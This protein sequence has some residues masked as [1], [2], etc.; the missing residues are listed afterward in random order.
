MI[1]FSTTIFGIFFIEI[2]SLQMRKKLKCK[3]NHEICRIL[4]FL[5]W[6]M[7][8]CMEMPLFHFRTGLM[9]IMSLRK[10]FLCK[11]R[12]CNM[13]EEIEYNESLFFQM[14]NKCQFSMKFYI[15]HT[16]QEYCDL[17]ITMV[18]NRY[19]TLTSYIGP[20]SRSYMSKTWSWLTL[21]KSFSRLWFNV[22]SSVQYFLIDCVS[23]FE[24][25]SEL[26]STE[27]YQ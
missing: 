19:Y 16:F 10:K 1:F 15:F 8:Y 3:C 13:M 12:I 17:L 20:C 4:Q 23:S 26:C 14:Q 6:M 24:Y 5:L 21:F 25:I 9:I 18:N 11:E 22:S 2:F 27:T 7:F